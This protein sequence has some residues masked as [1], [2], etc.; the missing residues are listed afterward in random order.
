MLA[1]RAT[2]SIST[3]PEVGSDPP[4]ADWLAIFRGVGHSVGGFVAFDDIIRREGWKSSPWRHLTV[5]LLT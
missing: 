2:A 4:E 5:D 3:P 1:K